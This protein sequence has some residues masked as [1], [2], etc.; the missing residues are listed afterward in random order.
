MYYSQCIQY[1]L[2]IYKYSISFAHYL[3]DNAAPIQAY[4][5]YIHFATGI[6]NIIYVP[7]NVS[8]IKH[9]PTQRSDGDKRKWNCIHFTVIVEN[10]SHFYYSQVV[11]TLIM[12]AHIFTHIHST[13]TF[14]VYY[15]LLRLY[16]YMIQVYA[17]YNTQTLYV[18]VLFV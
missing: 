3:C 5:H 7:A 18:Y 15:H 9:V 2:S 11:C 16:I 6:K 1:I 17:T 13:Y 12:Y 4:V 14:S 8:V 10:S